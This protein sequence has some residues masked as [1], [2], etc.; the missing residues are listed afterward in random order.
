MDIPRTNILENVI[1]TKQ[2]ITKTL[3]ATL[4][5]LPRPAPKSLHRN[6]RCK[7]PWDFFK[8]VFKDYKPDTPNLLVNCFDFDWSNTK[9]EKII[10]D[11]DELN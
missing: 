8:S 9:V 2:I 3:L 11:P 5:C 6:E 1:Q 7:T 10:K 4:K